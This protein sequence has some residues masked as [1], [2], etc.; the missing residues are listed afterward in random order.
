MLRSAGARLGWKY[1]M[2]D[3]MVACQTV[4]LKASQHIF[5]EPE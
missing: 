2:N 1:Q 5:W 3:D 4:E